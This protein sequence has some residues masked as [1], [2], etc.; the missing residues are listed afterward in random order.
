MAIGCVPKQAVVAE[1]GAVLV[2][3]DEEGGE[4]DQA[5]PAQEDHAAQP[6]APRRQRARLVCD[7]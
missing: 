7:L 2:E 5:Q 4:V 1:Q 3:R 6:P